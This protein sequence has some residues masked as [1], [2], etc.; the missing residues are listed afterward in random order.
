MY[1][2]ELRES[3]FPAQGGPEPAPMTIGDMLRQSVAAAPDQIALRELTYDGAIARSWTYAGLQADAERLARALASRHAEGARIAVYANNVPEWVLLEL[4][5][6]LAGVT[7]VTVN[8]AYQ[9]RELKYVLEQSRSEAI[10]YVAEFRGNPM[11]QIAD[12][13][14]DDIPAI[15][16][17]ILLT[18]HDALYDGENRGALRDPK[19]GDA[20]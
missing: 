6:G 14:C 5:C 7:L 4:A 3:H 15:T 12:A 11:Q 8:P 2:V 16:Y 9:K 17:R 1:K 13:V 10:Y 20:V 18:D 19:P